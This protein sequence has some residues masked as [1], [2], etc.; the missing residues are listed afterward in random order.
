MRF[1]QL[2]WTPALIFWITIALPSFILGLVWVSQGLVEAFGREETPR[3]SLPAEEFWQTPPAP[4][5]LQQ[6][7]LAFQTYCTACHGPEAQGIPGLGK[8]LAENAFIVQSSPLDLFEFV[9]RGRMV[10]DPANTTGI[11]MPPSGGNPTLTDAELIT[12]IYYLRSLQSELVN[13]V[14]GER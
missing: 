11:P 7:K 9:R 4:D 1:K 5:Q 13:S 2:R 10:S 12:I 8:N 3:V 14:E 6:G